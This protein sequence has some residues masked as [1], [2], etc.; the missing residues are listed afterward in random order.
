MGD[1][2]HQPQ[3][4]AGVAEDINVRAAADARDEH[5]TAIRTDI[6]YAQCLANR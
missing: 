6:D 2:A 4:A 1:V 5:S 3:R